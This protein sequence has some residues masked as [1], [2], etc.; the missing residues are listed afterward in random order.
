MNPLTAH[1]Q[2]QGISY[3]EHWF[4][5][6]GIAYRLIASAILFA[7][8]AVLPFITIAP[9]YDLEATIAY[10]EERNNW[11]ETAKVADVSV[12]EQTS[13][14]LNIFMSGGMPIEQ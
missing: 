9:R 5:A 8:H 7:L 14:S 6:I 12:S 4:F 3:L 1:P 11:I 10:L 13:E 2:E